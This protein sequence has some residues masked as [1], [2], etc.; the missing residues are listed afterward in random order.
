MYLEGGRGQGRE[1]VGERGE[2]GF[3]KEKQTNILTII[4]QQKIKIDR[5]TATSK[6]MPNIMRTSS[7]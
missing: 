4:E 7:S 3:Q 2:G 6:M 5:P 1:E